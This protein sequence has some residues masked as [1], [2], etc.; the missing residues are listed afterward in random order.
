MI[1]TSYNQNSRYYNK[2]IDTDGIPQDDLLR[3]N[4]DYDTVYVKFSEAGRLDLV[5]LRVYNTPINWWI[6]ARFNSI[7]DPS[8][9]IP[10]MAL[11]IPRLQ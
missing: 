2:D 4:Y 5:S 1:D 7:F 10:G 6:I 9:I 11:H 8:L 3:M